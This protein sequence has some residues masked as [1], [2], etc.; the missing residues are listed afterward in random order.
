MFDNLIEKLKQ[1]KLEKERKAEEENRKRQE[2]ERYKTQYTL[3]ELYVG[4]IVLFDS[5]V[6]EGHDWYTNNYY[7]VKKYAIL[8]KIDYE[9][10]LH[11]KSGQKLQKLGGWNAIVGDYTVRN[12]KTFQEAFP[13]FMR[14]NN[15]T[16]ST[17][18]SLE[19]IELMEDTMNEQLAPEQKNVVD[20]F[21]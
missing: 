9:E 12:V 8:I 19:I 15:F 10:Y 13:R 7:P 11:L 17:R 2:K 20:L 1:K 14:R 21:K 4:E 5:Q 3:D 18:A 6:Y 16:P